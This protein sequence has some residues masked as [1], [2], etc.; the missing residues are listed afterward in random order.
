M[1][2][3]IRIGSYSFYL[4]IL[5]A[6]GGFWSIKWGLFFVFRRGFYV[7]KSVLFFWEFKRVGY[8]MGHFGF[9][10]FLIGFQYLFMDMGFD[11][12]GEFNGV[13]ENII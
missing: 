6:A 2:N 13:P 12:V 5:S 4:S 8:L 1:G 3:Q 10:G 9:N 11:F 7:G